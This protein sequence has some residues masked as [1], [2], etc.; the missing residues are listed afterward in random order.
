MQSFQILVVEDFAPF[1]QFVCWA[2][3][4]RAEFQVSEASDGLEGVRKAEQL[5]P[6]LLVLDIGLPNLN[7]IEVCKCA[8]NVAPAAKILFVSQECSADI[9]REAFNTGAYGYVQKL[10]AQSELLSAVDTVLNGKRFVGSGL[11]RV[12]PPNRLAPSRTDH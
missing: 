4:K 6:D 5:Q 12:P 1:R 8:S 7:G 2:L 3:R 9:V 10:Y 11:L